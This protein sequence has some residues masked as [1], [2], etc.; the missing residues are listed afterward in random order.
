M[1]TQNFK[2]SVAA[3]LFLFIIYYS[4]TAQTSIGFRAGLNLSKWNT[5]GNNDQNENITDKSGK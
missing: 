5:E 2:K 1:F 4:I 3:V